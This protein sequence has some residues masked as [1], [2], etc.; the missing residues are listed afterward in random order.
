MATVTLRW[1]G[2]SDANSS[3][4]YAVYT[5]GTTPG[6][7]DGSALVT[8]DATSPYVSITTTLA[9]STTIDSNDTSLTVTST[10]SL[11]NGT[12]V[13][14]DEECILL[15]GLSGSTFASCTRG[16][17]GTIADEHEPL[18]TI[19]KLHESYAAT[20][21]WST[22]HVRRFKVYA[23]N[24]SS[25]S[26]AARIVAYNPTNPPDNAHCTVYGVIE[27]NAGNPVSGVVLTLEPGDG[28]N[29]LRPVGF[30]VA[31]YTKSATTDADG[32]FEFSIPKTRAQRQHGSTSPD[33]WT[34]TVTTGGTPQIGGS[35]IDINAEEEI[36]L[37]TIPDKDYANYLECV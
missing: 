32:Y 33:T 23:I 37:A 14:D 12:Y 25:T 9:N 31:N 21:T 3:T 20:V 2:A 13:R 16:Q 18:S 10:T 30:T 36:T 15:G 17:G 11:S 26:V 27:D 34:L 4:D 28:D 5:D 6:T 7:M 19:T 35:D 29:Y 24:G 1:A 22:R 8:Q